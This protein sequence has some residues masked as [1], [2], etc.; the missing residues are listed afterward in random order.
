[1]KKRTG[2]LAG[3]LAGCMIFGQ[4]V[5]AE[6]AV[7]QDQ[8]PAET[9]EAAAEINDDQ[10]IGEEYGVSVKFGEA[11]GEDGWV[12]P[13]AL[14]ENGELWNV[15]PTVECIGHNIK[16]QSIPLYC[17]KMEKYTASMI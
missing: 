2:I 15:Y 9:A 17:R 6:E 8:A 7:S 10:T 1:M 16:K 12:Y 5:F 13:Y 14:K 11:R 4:T 3:I